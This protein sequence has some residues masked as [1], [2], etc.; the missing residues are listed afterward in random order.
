MPTD[1]ARCPAS[2]IALLCFVSTLCPLVIPHLADAYSPPGVWD[3][4]VCSSY[5]T[6][7]NT[8]ITQGVAFPTTCFFGGVLGYYSATV[9]P[10][11]TTS[12]QTCCNDGV[13]D[14]STVH[15]TVFFDP[16]QVARPE[17]R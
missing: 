2:T 12:Y 9:C 14:S 8:T 4:S 10:L 11:T 15:A 17:L 13:G 6:I 5:P 3:A 7:C 1:I 16:Q